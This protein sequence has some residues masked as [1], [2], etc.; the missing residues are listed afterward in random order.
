[1]SSDEHLRVLVV[2]DDPDFVSLLRLL[3]EQELEARV[4]LSHLVTHRFTL[5]QLL[6]PP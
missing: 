6:K 3:L 2:E 5:D 4:D 1:M